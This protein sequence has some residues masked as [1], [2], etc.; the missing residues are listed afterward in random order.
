MR[1]E[2]LEVSRGDQSELGTVARVLTSGY[3]EDPVY[4]WAMPN[5]SFTVK[6]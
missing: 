1:N 2:I 3:A 6:R 5:E 4:L